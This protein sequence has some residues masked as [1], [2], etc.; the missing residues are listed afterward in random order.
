[1]RKSILATGIVVL[2]LALIGAGVAAGYENGLGIGVGAF[3]A[4]VGLIV[5]IYGG[6][7]QDKYESRARN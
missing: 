3:F 1:M 4:I 6:V 5:A 2:I 7:A